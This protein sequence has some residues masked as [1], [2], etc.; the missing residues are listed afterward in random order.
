[1]HTK[2]R[3]YIC[4]IGHRLVE[5]RRRR[6]YGAEEQRKKQCSSFA[7]PVPTALDSH[8]QAVSTCAIWISLPRTSLEHGNS[9][10][11]TIAQNLE[12]RI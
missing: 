10:E 2:L 11:C 9:V 4:G 5:T 1:M 6:R 7:G 3:K 8:G 12:A